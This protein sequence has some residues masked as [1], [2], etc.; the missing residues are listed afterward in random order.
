MTDV[1]DDKGEDGFPLTPGGNDRGMNFNVL[2]SSSR[3]YKLSDRSN[4]SFD[5]S[6]FREL[7]EF[8]SNQP[9]PGLT[10]LR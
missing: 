9:V 5:I 2:V 3:R 4:M 6:Y 8:E 7:F 10:H 1:G